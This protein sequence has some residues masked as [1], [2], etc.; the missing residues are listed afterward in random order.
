MVVKKKGVREDMKGNLGVVGQGEYR[1]GW[2]E[3]QE[4]RSDAVIL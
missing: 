4:G 2:R 3:E 1:R